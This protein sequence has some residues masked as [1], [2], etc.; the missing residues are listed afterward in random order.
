MK[1]PNPDK[2]YNNNDEG[3]DDNEYFDENGMK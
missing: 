2:N 3:T 1:E